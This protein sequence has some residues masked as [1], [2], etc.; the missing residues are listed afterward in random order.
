VT[1]VYPGG[2]QFPPEA[3]PLIVKFFKEHAKP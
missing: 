1:Y 3:P 2:H